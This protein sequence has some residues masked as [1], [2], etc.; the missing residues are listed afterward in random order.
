M[1]PFF[2]GG[3]Q[4]LAPHSKHYGLGKQALQ[5]FM[6]SYSAAKAQRAGLGNKGY[7]LG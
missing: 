3:G 1:I 6:L 2:G 4:Y 7:Q 5:P